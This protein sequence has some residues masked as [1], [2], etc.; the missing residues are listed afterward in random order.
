MQPVSLYMM[1]IVSYHIQY[2]SSATSCTTF[3]HAR[4]IANERGVAHVLLV[5]ILPTYKRGVACILL[6]CHAPFIIDYCCSSKCLLV[7]SHDVVLEQY[8]STVVLYI[9]IMKV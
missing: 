7:N 3:A 2:R 1:S 9:G 5:S 6:V 4:I 8:C